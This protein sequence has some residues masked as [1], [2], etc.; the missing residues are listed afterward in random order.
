[1]QISS[2]RYFRPEPWVGP[3]LS[4]RTAVMATC[5]GL[6]LG[7]GVC[8]GK[9]VSA[10]TGPPPGTA[11]AEAPA[12]PKWLHEALGRVP[13][14]VRD[15]PAAVDQLEISRKEGPWTGEDLALLA[16]FP[17][18]RDLEIV[19]GFAPDAL[20]R[21]KELERL[22]RIR[23]YS[24]LTEEDLK[25]LARLPGLKSLVLPSSTRLTETGMKWLSES[26]S[27][28]ELEIPY[29]SDINLVRPLAGMKGL[30]VLR[31]P[32]SQVT[33][34][35]MRAVAELKGPAALD[36]RLGVP[37]K[38]KPADVLSPLQGMANVEALKL[39]RWPLNDAAIEV[40]STL[41]NLKRLDLEEAKIG[42][43]HMAYVARL[44]NLRELNL[45]GTAIADA[46]VAYL[47]NL[48]ALQR[49]DLGRTRIT[50]KGLLSLRSLVNLEVLN[51]KGTQITDAGTSVLP[52]FTRLK[53][54]YLAST[55][56]GDT[57]ADYVG[58]IASLRTLT[59][60]E[61]SVTT[62]GMSLLTRL[63]NLEVLNLSD[64]SGVNDEGLVFIG[65]I[66]SLRELDLGKSFIA[67]IADS[68]GVVHLN[69]RTGQPFRPYPP[70]TDRGVAHL[71]NL[72]NL[73]KLNL[74]KTDVTRE[75]VLKALKDLKDLEVTFTGQFFR[76]YETLTV[77]GDAAN[78]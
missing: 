8:S 34:A 59:L 68:R 15:N 32:V 69:P 19:G 21:L 67:A 16:R 35:K 22:K 2:P 41:T 29:M 61:T 10:E 45:S 50:D 13:P 17:N 3:A 70:I 38:E 62:A 76:E 66:S 36:L 74:V 28:E 42:D 24:H 55:K 47:R 78:P 27:L 26:K 25:S 44:V 12:D 65:E 46:G 43:A 52:K 54:L 58:Q 57:T 6:L 4:C 73:R 64:C 72:R 31:F 60:R 75:G 18:L 37:I 51:L 9:V 5:V 20:G 1:M 39:A 77:G 63:K 53:E 71:R 11:V 23:L 40:V 33:E 48:V 49:L 14:G 7:F 30:K 56:V